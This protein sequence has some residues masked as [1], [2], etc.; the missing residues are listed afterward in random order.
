VSLYP[1]SFTPKS[2]YWFPFS[3]HL[4][5]LISNFPPLT[6]LFKTNQ[7]FQFPLFNIFNLFNLFHPFYPF[8]HIPRSLIN[9]RPKILFSLILLKFL[10]FSLLESHES[11]LYEEIRILLLQGDF[12]WVCIDNRLES[13]LFHF[14]WL[15][16]L[17]VDL[18]RFVLVVFPFLHWGLKLSVCPFLW[19]I[20]L[21][22]RLI[23]WRRPHK[24][25]L[26]LNLLL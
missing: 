5:P 3:K 7:I 18:D 20:P 10:L 12:P 4:K 19:F 15:E 8:H 1:L 16:L 11:F 22:L 6:F 13:C 17:F 24:L 14:L 9:S 23:C 21:Y 26:L 2:P 25:L